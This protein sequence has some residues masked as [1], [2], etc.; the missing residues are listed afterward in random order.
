MDG[1]FAPYRVERIGSFINKI[2]FHTA[3]SI[4]GV[5]RNNFY[6]PGYYYSLVIENTKFNDSS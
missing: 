2:S 5:E 3:L 6:V 4:G 1:K